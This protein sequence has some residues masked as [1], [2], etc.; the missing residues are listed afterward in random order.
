MVF[1]KSFLTITKKPKCEKS[2]FG[3]FFFD[4]FFCWM[5]R[6]VHRISFD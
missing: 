6:P 4:S 5:L 3:F 2:Y 1:S